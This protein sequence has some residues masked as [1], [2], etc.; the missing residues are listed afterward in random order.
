MVEIVDYI[1]SKI[2]ELNLFNST[3]GI[4]E[5]VEVDGKTFPAIY[6]NKSFIPVSDFK[7]SQ[8]YHRLT[9][10]ISINEVDS[11]VN[12]CD[13]AIEKNYPM[14]AVFYIDREACYSSYENELLLSESIE[15]LISFS[16]NKP[17][18]NELKLLNV[19]VVAKSIILDRTLLH[20]NEFNMSQKIGFEKL[21]FAIDYSIITQGQIS[22]QSLINC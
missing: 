16:S 12:G 7:E 9:G 19:S 2:S 8:V 14:R 17:M 10:N 5:L 3:Y 11:S 18:E 22:C 4:A 21:F 1:N 6:K 15:K 13:I 20:K